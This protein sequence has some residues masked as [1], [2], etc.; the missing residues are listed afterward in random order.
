MPLQFMVTAEAVSRGHRYAD[1]SQDVAFNPVGQI[2]G[3]MN[4]QESVRDLREVVYLDRYR[5]DVPFFWDRFGRRTWFVLNREELYDWPE[6]DRVAMERVDASHCRL[7]IISPQGLQTLLE[8]LCQ[9]MYAKMRPYRHAW[10]P[11]DMVIWDNWRF[12]HSVGGHP[13]KYPRTMQRT[14]INGD[15]GLGRLEDPGAASPAGVD[16]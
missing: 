7:P 11:T 12:I 10:S 15:Y 13:P 5:A 6:E 4:E 8:S 3:T 9:E 14:T 16:V 1:K 2:V